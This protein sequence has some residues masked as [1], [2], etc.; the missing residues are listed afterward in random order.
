MGTKMAET[1]NS[2]ITCPRNPNQTFFEYRLGAL[3]KGMSI[4]SPD[5]QRVVFL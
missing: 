4:C 1:A 2:A 3:E 5:H